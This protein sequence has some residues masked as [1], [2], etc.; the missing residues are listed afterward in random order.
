MLKDDPRINTPED[1]TVFGRYLVQRVLGEGAMGRVYLAEDPVLERLL[2]IK[3]IAVDKHTDSRTREE[4]LQRFSIEA[5]A[6]AKLNHS[7]IVTV[8]DAGEERGLPWIAFEYIDGEG[9]DAM[10]SGGPIEPIGK[11]ISILL[12]IA[13]ALHH[14]HECGIIHR[15]IKPA[16]ILIDRRTGIAKLSDFGVVK[17]PWVALTQDGSAVGSPGYMAPEQLDGSGT[18]FRSDLFSLGIVLYQMLTGKHPFLRKSIPETIFATL[19]NDYTPLSDLRPDTPASLAQ[20]AKNLLEPDRKKRIQNAAELLRRL[21][22]AERLNQT[23]ASATSAAPG[24]SRSLHGNATRLRR[25]RETL[26][27]RGPKNPRSPDLKKLRA[28]F[29]ASFDFAVTHGQKIPG[30][31]YELFLQYRPRRYLYIVIPSTAL[32]LAAT[33]LIVRVIA[34]PS[35]ERT[36]LKSLHEEG[37]RGSAQKITDSCELLLEMDKVTEAKNGA[38]RLANMRSCASSANLVLLRAALREN[39]DSAAA[40]ALSLATASPGWKTV[41]AEKLDTLIAECRNRMRRKNVE[42]SALFTVLA[43]NL[44]KQH[45]DTISSWMENEQ[46]WLRWNS[47]GIAAALGMKVDSVALYIL[48]LRHAGSIRTRKRAATRLGELGDRRAVEPLKQAGALGFRDPV[49][50]YTAQ[51]VLETYFRDSIAP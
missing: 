27:T 51:S 2:A 29:L 33:L 16:N 46:Y 23:S 47:V 28:R 21:H 50:S 9:L 13:A 19:H 48:D 22:A 26:K 5:R 20:I 49:L 36:I 17:A 1:H 3:V 37:W 43:R 6:C 34:G 4:F 32:L 15:D 42:D 7:S 41:P 24:G 39:D 38:I 14:A 40:N 11:V 8:F 30:R 12:D 10:L 18:D 31:L 35:G 45:K 25:I 44:F